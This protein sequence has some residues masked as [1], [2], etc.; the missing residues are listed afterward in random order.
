MNPEP[1]VF[2][3]GDKSLS[4]P[5]HDELGRSTLAENLSNGLLRMSKP[6]GYVVAVFGAWGSGKSTLLSFVNHFL[7]KVPENNR[8]IIVEFNPW[9]FSGREDL[10]LSFFNQI[11][12]AIDDGTCQVEEIQ[13]LIAEFAELVS[14]YPHWTAKV[15]G[16]AAKWFAG[17]K[18]SVP[19]LK[20]KLGERLLGF[21][22]RVI[23][24][25]DDID[26]LIPGEILDTLRLV[27]AV[28]DLPN[29]LYLLAVDRTAVA[30]AIASATK[31]DGNAYLEKIVQLPIE[32]PKPD[33]ISIQ[34]MFSERV[35]GIL[36][37]KS[38]NLFDKYYW[39]EV[40]LEGIDGFLR[41][42]RD[43]IRLTN[44]LKLTYPMVEGEVNPVDFIALEALR[45][46]RPQ[47]YDQIR[48]HPEQFAGSTESTSW[49]KG[50][51]HTA[52]HNGWMKRLDEGQIGFAAKI[53]SNVFPKFE[54][55]FRDIHHSDEENWRR[56][57]RA[58]SPDKFPVYFRLDLPFG[59]I[60]RSVLENLAALSASPAQFGQ[61]LLSFLRQLR[62][63]GRTR[64]SQALVQL[65][66]SK[67]SAISQENICGALEALLDIGDELIR[68]N[69]PQ[70]LWGEIDNRY[71]LSRLSSRLLGRLDT[72]D[73]LESL[74]KHVSA[75]K[76]LSTIVLTVSGLGAEH[77]KPPNQ[78]MPEQLR[79]VRADELAVLEQLVAKIIA[80]AAQAGSLVDIPEFVRVLYMWKEWSGDEPFSNWV[81]EYL[82][83]NTNL[84]LFLSRL[85]PDDK[86]DLKNDPISDL[87]QRRYLAL[88]HDFGKI[89]EHGDRIERLSRRDDL[90]DY[91]RI[92]LQL[93][94]LDNQE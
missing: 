53:L 50:E 35:S 91:D 13:R 31:I 58:C 89:G 22:R 55:A 38:T 37:E 66:D 20:E 65:G 93:L 19:E 71:R 54:S 82:V 27:K 43:V 69:E 9:W 26:R 86:I 28:G 16:L 36:T 48:S 29:T 25:I 49:E 39:G 70:G 68:A 32:L 17:R 23:V 45:I 74:K 10:T 1:N 92:R 61:A 52:F 12:V 85:I 24:L 87:R 67:A 30:D 94:M 3:L 40:Y 8:P 90:S 63:D 33:R 79:L 64:V 62:P 21:G 88:V 18:R 73:R 83:S 56:L 60:S 80:D 47:V 51:D 57:L 84:L 77:G 78:P 59:D 81:R 6:E 7:Q 75:G 46:F 2:L 42:P 72:D 14:H 34:S 4:D 44:A 41:T 15:G 11:S 5:A 76:A